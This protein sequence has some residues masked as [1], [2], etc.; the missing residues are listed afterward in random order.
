MGSLS[1]RGELIQGEVEG[2]QFSPYYIH[3]HAGADGI[4]GAACTCPYDWGGWCKHIVAVLLTCVHEPE[5]I[6]ERPTLQ[7]LLA[8]LDREQLHALLLEL[9]ERDPLLADSIENKVSV[10][11]ADSDQT[12]SQRQ[13]DSGPGGTSADQESLRRRI[14]SI[15]HGV[16]HTRSSETYWRVAAVV[17]ELNGVVEQ[18]W[19]YIADGDARNALDILEVF[20][21]EFVTSWQKLDTSDGEIG[22]LVYEVGQ[23]W[24][25]AILSAGLPADE[26]ERWSNRLEKWQQTVEEYGVAD[27]FSA[28]IAAAEE[29]WHS[30]SLQR[31][32]KGDVIEEGILPDDA[33]YPVEILITARLNVLERQGRFQEYVH[34]AKAGGQSEL[35]VRMLVRLGRTREAVEFGLQNLLTTD[36]A[37]TLVRILRSQDEIEESM[38][39]AEQGLTLRGDKALLAIWLRDMAR[40]TGDLKRAL[41]AAVIV[42]RSQPDLD[43]YL[44]AKDLAGERWP[45]YRAE[46]LDHLRHLDSFWVAGPVEIFLHE[47]LVAD[48]I[49]VVDRRGDDTLVARVVE[50]ALE[51]NPEWVIQTCR[52]RAERIMDSGKSERYDNAV[53]WLVKAQEAYRAAGRDEDWQSYL[54]DLLIH[55]RRKYRLVPML[56]ALKER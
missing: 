51:S 18:A 33:P 27:A 48:A 23:A 35:Y 19:S 31:V 47:G 29:G 54:D 13:S 16:G 37:L 44:E 20:T 43:S 8:G 55:H 12:I 36:E 24:T 40:D 45:Q 25:E 34:L 38:R 5:K 49:A 22:D 15:V 30:W 7:D 52:R 2:S 21:D 50:A 42:L 17:D 6:V 56:K 28:A 26:L 3:L 41:A 32:L 11:Q 46:I 10:L 53:K 39:V 1:R 14:R 9:A 4:A